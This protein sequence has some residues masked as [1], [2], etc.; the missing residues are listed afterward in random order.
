MAKMFQ[1]MHSLGGASG[2][3]PS[4]QLFPA[5]D[6]AQLSTP[7]NIKILVMYDIVVVLEIEGQ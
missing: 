3:A 1:Y 5:D 2:F 7:V 4:A 6:P